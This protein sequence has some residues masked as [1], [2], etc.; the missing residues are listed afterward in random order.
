[1]F[2]RGTE[3]LAGVTVIDVTPPA[4]GTTIGLPKAP[5]LIVR[6]PESNP[7]TLGV[8]VTPTLQFSPAPTLEPHVLL[9]I[10]KSPVTAT[11]DEML[12]AALRLFVN[13]TVLAALV[14]PMAVLPNTRLL[15]EKVTG[16]EPVP[17]RATI[18]GPFAALSEN[19]KIP[20]VA[21]VVV[22]ENVTPT[23]QVAGAAAILGWQVLLD[24][25]KP[26]LVN[27]LEKSRATFS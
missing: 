8:N 3:G 10:A 26:A 25:A 18:C 12:R 13:V 22:G 16:E 9:E 7:V 23:V 2:P 4:R 15:G 5:K 21:P 27:T 19:V 17:L 1:V 11:P 6:A 20:L 14:L 24:T